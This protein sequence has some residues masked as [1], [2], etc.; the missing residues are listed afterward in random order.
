MKVKDIYDVIAHSFSFR[1]IDYPYTS[2]QSTVISPNPV[3]MVRILEK[4][5]SGVIM[6]PLHIEI[7]KERE[8]DS[9][10]VCVCYVARVT[11]LSLSGVPSIV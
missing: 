1:L 10:K 5:K 2:T 7:K 8:T 3:Q 4:H 9:R 6:V 11:W